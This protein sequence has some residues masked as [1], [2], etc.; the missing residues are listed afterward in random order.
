MKSG[1]SLVEL[2]TELERQLAS[3]KDMVVPSNL[4]NHHTN[5]IGE[6]ILKIEERD[7]QAKYGITE[8]VF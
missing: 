5:D 7:G 6:T 1:R 4:M 3:K 8:N 2:A